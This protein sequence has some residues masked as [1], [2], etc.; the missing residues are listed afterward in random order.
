LETPFSI[1]TG[2]L[3]IGWLERDDASFIYQLVNDPDWL[4]FIGDRGV[5]SLDAARE[6]IESGPREMYRRYGFGLYR[7]A[8]SSTQQP[9][10]ICG[11]LQRETL[12]HADL[13]FAFLPGFRKQGYAL[14]AAQAILRH[15]FRH[16]GLPRICAIVSTANHDSRNLLQKLGFSFDRKIQNGTDD[17]VLD[18]FVIDRQN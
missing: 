11:I 6:Y 18:L 17:G 9:I 7:V 10:G 4:R 5:S 14:E 1:E 13:G 3:H 15:E 16:S 12:E 8:L 2:R